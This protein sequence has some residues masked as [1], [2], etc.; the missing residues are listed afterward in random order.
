MHAFEVIG[1]LDAVGDVPA[2]FA[3]PVMRGDIIAHQAENHHHHMFGH[4]DAVRIG[5]LRDGDPML[6]SG[7]EVGVI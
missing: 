3:Y 4:A 1:P 6:I 5:D 7:F 2:A